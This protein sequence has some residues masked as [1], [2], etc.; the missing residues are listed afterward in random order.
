MYFNTLSINQET[1]EINIYYMVQKS[2]FVLVNCIIYTAFQK[3][4][5]ITTLNELEQNF[6]VTA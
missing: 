1:A 3:K 6:V 4:E 2:K 5:K